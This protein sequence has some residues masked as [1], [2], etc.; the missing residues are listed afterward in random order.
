MG[1]EVGCIADWRAIRI[2]RGWWPEEDISFVFR[3]GGQASRYDPSIATV[4]DVY[5]PGAVMGFCI[6]TGKSTP[7]ILAQE[8][9]SRTLSH[10]MLTRPNYDPSDRSRPEVFEKVLDAARGFLSETLHANG[11]LSLTEEYGQFFVVEART[12]D[13]SVAMRVEEVRHI[14]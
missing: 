14:G 13:N 3:E 9:R 6:D 10:G 11:T 7:V 4:P 5:Y 2:E 1:R 8:P 12:A